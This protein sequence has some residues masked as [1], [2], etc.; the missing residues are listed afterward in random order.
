MKNNI[1]V[2]FVPIFIGS[3]LLEAYLIK[4]RLRLNHKETGHPRP[5]VAYDTKDAL[6]SISMGIGNLLIGV[7]VGGLI[8]VTYAWVYQ[9]KLFNIPEV[10]WAYVLM[11]VIEDYVYYWN[12]RM[13]HISRL[14]WS[15]HET[16]HSSNEYN[17]STA[18]RQTWTG[19]PLT[20]IFWIPLVWLGFPP[21]WVALQQSISLIFQF[22]IHTRLVG[23][24]GWLEWIFNTPSHHRVHHGR[25]VK[26]LDY[27]Y[28]GIFIIWDRLHGTFKKEEEEPLYGT[29]KPL[30]TKNI[31]Y[32]GF[33]MWVELWQGLRRMPTWKDRVKFVFMPPGWTPDGTGKTARQLQRDLQMPQSS[34]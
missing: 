8:A 7:A 5:P 34:S 21:V 17:L 19:W 6:S 11:V 3:I 18:V 32:I 22:F 33:H 4:K 24:L 10:W 26:Y 14:W 9:Y 12:H 28:A 20:W 23:K 15:A 16:H 1:L 2:T 27:N 30:Q 13:G 29:Y 25:D 31:F